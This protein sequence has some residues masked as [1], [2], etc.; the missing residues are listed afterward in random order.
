MAEIN[1]ACVGKE[2]GD[3]KI[4]LVIDTGASR[5]ILTENDWLKLKKTEKAMKLKK[6]TKKFRPYGVE[7]KLNC[8]GKMKMKLKSTAGSSTNSYVFVVKGARESLLGLREAE[9][10]GIVKINPNGVKNA[11]EVRNLYETTLESPKTENEV[12]SEGQTQAEID[13]KMNEIK[14]TFPKVFTDKIGRATKVE[15]VH[16]TIDENITPVQQ[17]RRKI[18]RSR[19]FSKQSHSVPLL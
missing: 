1:F 19:V 10:L 11:E 3:N 13:E 18:L 4:N 7:S 6:T 14:R 17:K 12:V 5:V 8:L 16:V 2:H 9:R 15:P